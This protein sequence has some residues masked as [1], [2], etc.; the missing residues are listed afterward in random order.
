MTFF[1]WWDQATVEQR[2]E[3]LKETPLNISNITERDY[4]RW[5][6][7]NCRELLQVEDGLSHSQIY[8]LEAMYNQQ[9]G[10]RK[11]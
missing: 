8:R 1:Q 3:L 4:R 10:E 5:A 9:A 6:S 11:I 7:R 2:L